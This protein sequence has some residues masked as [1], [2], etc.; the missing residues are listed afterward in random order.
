MNLFRLA[1]SLTLDTDDYDKGLDS[2]EGKAT[3]FG[4]KLGSGL[5]KAAA[6]TGA[7]LAAAS[8]AVIAFGKASI[9]TGREFDSAMSQIAATLGLTMSDIQ[10]NVN[11]AGDTFDALRDKA[12][13]MGSETNFTAKEAAE[14]L[15]ILAMSG[16][17][18]NSSIAMIEDVLHLAAA[19]SMD[20]A[21]AAGYVSGAMKGF[22]DATKDSGYY[23]DLMAKGATLANTSVQELGEAMASGAAGA[24]AYGQNAESMTVA[25]LRL[26]EQG[27]AG[28][29][30][31]TALS[32]AMKNLYSPT[33]QAAKALK[34]LGV[35]AYDAATGK[36]RDFNTVVNELDAALVGYTDE[37]RAAYKQTIFGIQGLD[38]YNKM[39]VTGISKQQQWSDALSSASEGMGE[40]AKQYETMTDNLQGDIDIFNSALDGLK[41]GVSDKLMPTVRQFVKFGSSAISAITEGFN[42]G[43]IAGAMQAFGTQI[44]EG[45]ALV[46][47]ILPEITEAGIQLIEALVLGIV[48]NLPLI[49]DAV[50]QISE[51]LLASIGEIMPVLIPALIEAIL[52]I[53]QM[54]I[55][56][57]PDILQGALTLFSGI[58]E[59]LTA[60][61]PVIIEA[62]P[63]IITGIVDFI[64]GAIPELIQAG[65]DLLTA[66]VEAMPEIIAAIVEVLPDIIEAILTTLTDN[67]PL[68]IQA[69]IDLLTALVT[70]L[71]EIIATIVAALPQIIDSILT[72]LLNNLP[73]LIRAGV[74]LLTALIGALPEI[75]TTIVGA[76]P[77]IIDGILN[78]LI[79]NIPLIIEAG[80]QLFVALIENLPTIIIEIVKA[81]PE[82]IAGIVK[83]IGSLA[84]K[85][86]EA[87]GNLLKGIW[88]GISGAANWLWN[89]VKEWAGGLLDKIKGFFGIHSPSS[90]MRELIGKNLMVGLGDGISKYGELAVDA[91]EQVSKDILDAAVNPDDLLTA[92]GFGDVDT[93]GMSAYAKGVNITNNVYAEAQKPSEIF[94]E[95]QRRTET[96]LWTNPNDRRRRFDY[97]V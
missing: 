77:E 17:D 90:V 39:T 75:I 85:L 47:E 86:V 35:N 1:A 41:L 72:A 95:V 29:A 26:A 58:V 93:T 15:N 14:G 13:Q 96:V 81:I 34:E 38:A 2:S 32:A 4:Q 76:L 78:A 63:Q 30:A 67:L 54:L 16:Y 69:G 20:M 12:I 62:L 79:D 92:H 9:D 66:L 65:I 8:T 44:S 25:L 21:S 83:A 18:A 64:T 50:L 5:G 31:G 36:A 11:G 61:L 87:G 89:K 55:D 71:P 73:L 6:V 33:D 3:T 70:A 42:S 43:G 82:I 80:V 45:I 60:A 97:G 48:D 88:E 52:L 51:Q 22:N 68:L 59:G 23:A 10:N 49:A 74:D 53:V 28:A 24:A 27:E 46:M 94:A 84:Y 37:Q 91:M 7:A 40:A 57:A 56:H 19:G